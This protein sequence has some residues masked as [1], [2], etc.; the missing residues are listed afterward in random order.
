MATL[1]RKQMEQ[2]LAQGGS[3]LY[4]GQVITQADALPTDAD[5]AAG[6]PTREQALV[7]KLQADI[8]AK[9]AELESLRKSTQSQAPAAKK[10]DD[11]NVAELD[12]YAKEHNLTF[13]AEA[14]TKAKKLE[15][16][17]A[18]QGAG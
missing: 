6:D 7:A 11:M 8:A 4:N 13:P 14:D 5:L 16:L 3:V 12:A 15:V 1:T 9:N 18:S 10:L 2:V 17:K